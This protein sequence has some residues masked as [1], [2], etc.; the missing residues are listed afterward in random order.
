MLQ[1]A[2]R[3]QARE[4]WGAISA[5][6]ALAAGRIQVWRLRVRE[7]P[8]EVANV[9]S[10]Q[11][12]ESIARRRREEDRQ[13]LTASYAALRLL[14]G[15]VLRCRPHDIRY[16][17]GPHGKP[18][19]PGKRP[20]AHFNLSHSGELCLIALCPDRE[21]GVDVEQVDRCP[22]ATDLAR[23]FFHS[24]EVEAL[25]AMPEGDRARAFMRLWVCKEA[26]V[27]ARGGGLSMGLNNF[28]V[29]LAQAGAEALTVQ[30]FG[31]EDSNW[32]LRLLEPEAGYVGAIAAEGEDWST[33]LYSFEFA[34]FLDR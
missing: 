29:P 19:L 23:R 16:A 6:P 33:E 14:L 5:P 9:L 21:V 2:D 7:A 12:L 30:M 10:A 11:E 4:Q 8:A 28:A 3:A 34:N 18:R 32:R 22:D 24:A 20:A 13:S 25:E 1:D 26:Y 15:A 27:K 31:Q 17:I